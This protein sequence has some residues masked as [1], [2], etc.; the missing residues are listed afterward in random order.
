MGDGPAAGAGALEVLPEDVQVGAPPM[1][2]TDEPYDY[3]A[4]IPTGRGRHGRRRRWPAVLL[5]VLV[6]LVVVAVVG[7]LH[8]NKEINPPG[9]P[10]RT[11][12]VVVPRG[13]STSRA[14][15]LLA[16]DGVI[17]GSTV[18]ALSLIHI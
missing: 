7:F 3:F 14:A 11:V 12:T 8:V 13:T 1:S 15:D 6:A 5:V 2:G 9:K 16:E 10:G 18:F 4:D 17:H